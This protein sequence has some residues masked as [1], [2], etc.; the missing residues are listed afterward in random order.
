MPI[1]LANYFKNGYTTIEKPKKNK[2][3]VG[4]NEIHLYDMKLTL[5]HFLDR[6]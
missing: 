5:K 1:I 2:F 3:I 6:M 4:K